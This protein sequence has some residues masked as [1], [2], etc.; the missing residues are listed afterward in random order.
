MA[1]KTSPVK[2]PAQSAVAK[3]VIAALGEYLK[4]D[5]RKLAATLS[6]REDLGLDSLAIIELL[7]RIEEAFNLSIPDEDLEKL[8]TVG[9]VIAY[10]EHGMGP[11]QPP[12]AAPK[13]AKAKKRR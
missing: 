9:D 1:L 13:I 4:K 6:L 7:Y 2:R 10:I 12:T 3:Q 8:Q 5:E 11:E